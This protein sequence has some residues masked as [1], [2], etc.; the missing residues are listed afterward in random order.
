MP[1]KVVTEYVQHEIQRAQD[2]SETVIKRAYHAG[3]KKPFFEG[4]SEFTP[5]GKLQS[6]G[7]VL[8]DGTRA[9]VSGSQAPDIS[10]ILARE[11]YMDLLF[12]ETDPS[13]YFRF[14]DI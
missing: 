10:H 6:W 8:E 14:F 3:E 7:L 4:F 1:K 5:A 9:V 13:A 2:G 11:E 12:G